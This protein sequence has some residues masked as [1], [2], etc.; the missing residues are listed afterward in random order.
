MPMRMSRRKV[1]AVVNQARS[2]KQNL[3]LRSGV[4]TPLPM[5]SGERIDRFSKSI[6]PAC[7]NDLKP[8]RPRLEHH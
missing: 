2:I 7:R 1:H 4:S 6:L 5:K 8:V 3:A